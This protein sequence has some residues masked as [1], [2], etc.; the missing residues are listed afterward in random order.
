MCD[1]EY[2]D[3]LDMNFLGVRVKDHELDFATMV[4]QRSI[5]VG[6]FTTILEYGELYDLK[7]RSGLELITLGKY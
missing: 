5:P 6:G 4:S 3:A 2:Y 7:K 1:C